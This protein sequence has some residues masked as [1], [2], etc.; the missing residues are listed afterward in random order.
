LEDLN[1]IKINFDQ[2]PYLVYTLIQ[3]FF[4][5]LKGNGRY[6]TINAIGSHP[7]LI[8]P[9]KLRNEKDEKIEFTD[10]TLNETLIER[11]KSMGIKSP[12]YIQYLSLNEILARDSHVMLIAETGGGK[13]LCY[14]LPIIES[15]IRIK[16]YIERTQLK[17]E[18]NQPIAI[19]LVPTREL[20]FQVYRFF[21]KLV[22]FEQALANQHNIGGKPEH[23]TYLEYLN[24][25]NVVVDLH[26]SVIESKQ[27]LVAEKINSLDKKDPRPVDVLI[28]LP[29][30]LEDRL[31]REKYFNSLYLR[32]L[33]I[34]EADTLLDDSF[35]KVTI[36]CL[37]MLA[38]NLN[39]PKVS[40]ESSSV[41]SEEEEGADE[42]KSKQLKEIE[43]YLKL[44]AKLKEPSTQLTFASATV[45][46]KLKSSLE[47]LINLETE[48]K[49]I[50]T[51]RINRLMLHIP[52][53]FI[54]TNGLERPKLLLE[55]LR[56][57]LT[58]KNSQPTIMVFCYRTKTA[59]YVARYLK[60]NGIECELLA[61]MVHNQE[62][63]RIVES[64]LN[65][66]TR[67][68]CCTD[69]ASRG[70]DTVHVSH[71]INFEMPQYIADYLHR[72]GRVGRLNTVKFSGSNGLVT[73]LIVNEF[74][75]QL[76]W[77]IEKSIRLG[78]EL[79]NVNANIKNLY[80]NS[81]ML[82]KEGQ[83]E[84]ATSRAPSSRVKKVSDNE[85]EAQEE[86]EETSPD[87]FYEEQLEEQ[88]NDE[89]K[90]SGKV[91]ESAAGLSPQI[92]RTNRRR[93]N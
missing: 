88:S 55:L 10:L 37:N 87:R 69:I 30:Q 3:L 19:V 11:L 24:G 64:F 79:E 67:V 12:T 65:G 42:E 14:A 45:P 68:L 61:K 28:T 89:H 16:N 85:D 80:R 41:L 82:E 43:F 77:N 81:Y 47:N 40:I 36:N 84:Q 63:E 49:T 23:Q 66:Q 5:Y 7:S 20:A 48:M 54:R 35:S 31:K 75:A 59:H 90:E 62:R 34:D 32:Q 91:E 73:N 13:T 50:R 72:V 17:R 4:I 29:G 74:D 58:R 52:Q 2:Q 57:D 92:R 18:K 21:N 53:K 15:C 70:W 26:R 27:A 8:S 51:S 44:D 76:V 71:V 60:E 25:L 56:K 6:F 83:K 86:E 78:V 22:H 93:R 33:V 39:L 46:T 9:E 38:L 1:E